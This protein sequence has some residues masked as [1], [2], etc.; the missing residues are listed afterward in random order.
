MMSSSSKKPYKGLLKVHEF[1]QTLIQQ[2]KAEMF[3][4]DFHNRGHQEEVDKLDYRK[5]TIHS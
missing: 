2:I 3:Q 1:P 4:C 5:T